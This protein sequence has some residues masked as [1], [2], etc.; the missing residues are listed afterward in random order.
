MHPDRPPP[1][2]YSYPS[3]K[4]PYYY[5]R[6]YYYHP[7]QYSRSYGYPLEYSRQE[8]YPPPPP[9]PTHDWNRTPLPLHNAPAAEK[10]SPSLPEDVKPVSEAPS[11]HR[12]QSSDESH[13]KSEPKRYHCDWPNCDRSFYRPSSLKTHYNMH[14]GEKPFTWS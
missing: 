9:P 14:T 4:N 1:E 10:G 2:Y 11:G 7:N 3:N 13:K 12:S 8:Y 6:P 5:Y